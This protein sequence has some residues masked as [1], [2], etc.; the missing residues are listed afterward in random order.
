MRTDYAGPLVPM[1]SARGEKTAK[2]GKYRCVCIVIRLVYD[3]PEFTAR[4]NDVHQMRS[5]KMTRA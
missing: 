4:Q 1:A 2:Q 5:L 3:A